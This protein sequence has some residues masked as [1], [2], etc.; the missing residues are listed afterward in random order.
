MKRRM[1]YARGCV[2]A[3]V[4]GCALL[5]FAGACGG[6]DPPPTTPPDGSS[7]VNPENTG[8][9]CKAPVDCYP[10]ID[11][12]TLAGEV[13][14]LD[15]VEGGYCTHLCNT[16]DDCCAVPGEC[17]AGLKQV[18]APFESTGQRMCFLSCEEKDIRA[19][20]DAGTLPDGGELDETA[21]CTRY[22][23]SAFACRSTGGGSENRK[24]CVP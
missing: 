20:G 22:T 3:V 8:Q 7:G 18:C 12:G 21:Y 13:K 24:V 15:R 2:V 17:K 9:T 16:D 14:C 11:A 19:A 5:G 6:S 4:A 10:G 1:D 23:S